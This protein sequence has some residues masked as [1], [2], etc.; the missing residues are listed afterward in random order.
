MDRMTAYDLR[1]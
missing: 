1:Y